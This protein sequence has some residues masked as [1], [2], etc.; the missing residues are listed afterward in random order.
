MHTSL[1]ARDH[2]RYETEH[3]SN[4]RGLITLLVCAML[5]IGLAY[6]AMVL[7]TSPDSWVAEATLTSFRSDAPVTLVA[8]ADPAR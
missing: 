4:L 5:L 1:N 7:L 6:A 2:D 3:H 8:T